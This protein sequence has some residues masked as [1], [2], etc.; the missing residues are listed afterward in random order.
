M[1][2]KNRDNRMG[3]PEES[4]KQGQASTESGSV[5]KTQG[6]HHEMP[7]RQRI[8]RCFADEFDRA[9]KAPIGRKSPLDDGSSDVSQLCR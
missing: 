4:V 8:R 9:I 2:N 7:L 1:G 6:R 5:A 3:T